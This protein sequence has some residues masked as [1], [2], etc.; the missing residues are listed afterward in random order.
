MT[1]RTPIPPHRIAPGAVAH[2]RQSGE[3]GGD[4]RGCGPS[5]RRLRLP[6]ERDESPLPGVDRNAEPAGPTDVIEQAAEDVERGLVDTERRGIPSDVPGPRR[7]N[8]E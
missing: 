4:E 7:R 1:K 5:R 8:R 2:A 3:P 6:H